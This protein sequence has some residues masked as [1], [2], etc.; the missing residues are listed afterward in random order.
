VYSVRR[1]GFGTPKPNTR[2]GQLRTK[3]GRIDSNQGDLGGKHVGAAAGILNTGGNV[4]GF[5]API[6]TP[7]AAAR[8]GWSWALY[9]GSTPW[10]RTM[11]LPEKISTRP[12]GARRAKTCCR[13]KAR[14]RAVRID[15]E[16]SSLA[17]TSARLTR[18]KSW[19]KSSCRSPP[20]G[21]R[22]KMRV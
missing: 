5:L 13:E 16:D 19:I 17:Q 9:A 21:A 8:L 11:F 20:L 10:M 4:G 3:Q 15:G 1:C 18:T 2:A 14:Q 7:F 22:W 6:M 12:G